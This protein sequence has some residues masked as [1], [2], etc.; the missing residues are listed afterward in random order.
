[1]YSHKILNAYCFRAQ[2]NYWPLQLWI[3]LAHASPTPP[4]AI[5]PTRTIWKRHIYRL[6]SA[7]HTSINALWP[8]DVIW[9]HRYESSLAQVMSCC[10]IAPS[11]HLNQCWLIINDDLWCSPKSNFTAGTRILHQNILGG[12]VPDSKVHGANMGPTWVL[13]APP[14]PHIGPMNF[15]IWGGLQQT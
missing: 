10:M 4:V 13:S 6:Y 14:G 12:V 2:Q 11:H 3:N 1:M 15:A 9:R 7:Y 5:W 8:S